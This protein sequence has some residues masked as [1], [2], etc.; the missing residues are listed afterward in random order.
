M[1]HIIMQTLQLKPGANE[2]TSIDL[3]SIYLELLWDEQSS[4]SLV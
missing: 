4:R 1:M 2:K 3:K